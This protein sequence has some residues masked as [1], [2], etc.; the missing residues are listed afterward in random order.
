MTVTAAGSGWNPILLPRFGGGWSS[1]PQGSG[2]GAAVEPGPGAAAGS[3]NLGLPI[4]PV[5]TGSRI[6]NTSV[7]FSW[8]W[9]SGNGGITLLQVRYR[10]PSGSGAYS[11]PVALALDATFYDL[12]VSSGGNADLYVTV[13]NS[14]GSTNS[15]VASASASA[16]SIT[17]TGMVDRP[18]AEPYFFQ[19]F[20]GLAEGATPTAAGFTSWVN[21]GGEK[22]TLLDGVGGGSLRCD[23]QVANNAFPHIGIYTPSGTQ[24]LHIYF[25]FKLYGSTSQPFRQLKFCRA[26]T[27]T[28][29][30]PIED[31]AS[32]KAKFMPSIYIYPPKNVGENSV[33]A[34]WQNAALQHIGLTPDSTGY[35]GTPVA[36]GSQPDIDATANWVCTE[37]HYKLNTISPAVANGLCKMITNGYVQHN[38]TAV[39]VKTTADEDLSFVQFIPSL[40]LDGNPGE[41]DYAISRVYT[42]TYGGHIC[43]I[44]ASTLA[45]ATK[46]FM[47]KP[48]APFSG[49]DW[50]WDPASEA[51][52]PTDC[53]WVCAVDSA[54][55]SFVEY[56]PI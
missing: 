34:E 28:N 50:F 26:G 25:W 51:G 56:R 32:T 13:A 37:T 8:N 53:D 48:I 2:S 42:D 43:R 7:R 4:A 31:Y 54:G 22:V 45:A 6:T 1:F 14:A 41:F 19:P 20:V 47:L 27:R 10:T 29:I 18:T 23:P 44:N 33:H 30:G 11:A 40:D 52:A 9:P 12:A 3:G 38:R 21:R 16:N 55:N 24:Q 49:A 39:P 35:G 46:K 17:P 36:P 5:V 15:N